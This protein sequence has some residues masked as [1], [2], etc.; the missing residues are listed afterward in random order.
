MATG[1][2]DTRPTKVGDVL[3]HEYDPCTGYCREVVTVAVPAGGLSIG[4]VLENTTS[5]TV[6]NLV[7]AANVSNASAVLIDT[8]VNDDTT[9]NGNFSLAVLTDG[10]SQVADDSLSFAADVDTPAERQSAFDALETQG[11]KVL[12]QV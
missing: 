6:Y 12:Q 9:V 2:I 3:K 10:P 11:I 4:A 5:S 1:L 7:N 8:L